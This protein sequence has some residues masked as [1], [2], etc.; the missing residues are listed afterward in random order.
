M[1]RIVPVAVLVA[2]LLAAGGLVWAHGASRASPTPAALGTAAGVEPTDARTPEPE[3]MRSMMDACQR[4]MDD[5]EMRRHMQEHRPDP[6]MRRMMNDRMRGM[7]MM[8][9][10]AR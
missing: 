2:V 8:P 3:W 4:A 5:P 1:W 7:P 6:G 9:G 10:P